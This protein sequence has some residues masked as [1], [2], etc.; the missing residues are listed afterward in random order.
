MTSSGDN[1]NTALFTVLITYSHI[2]ERLQNTQHLFILEKQIALFERSE[3]QKKEKSK[4]VIFQR[5]N[6]GDTP[7]A[8][9]GLSS[10]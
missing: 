7:N 2:P 10:V 8:G 9:I 3:R 4:W 1:T 6:S 5:I